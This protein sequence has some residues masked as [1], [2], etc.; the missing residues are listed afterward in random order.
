[1]SLSDLGDSLNRHLAKAGRILVVD[2]DD[3]TR[4]VIEGQL[5]DLGFVVCTVHNG[6]AALTELERFN[7]DLVLLDLRMPV[8]DGFRTLHLLRRS[9]KHADIPVVICSATEISASERALLS[10]SAQGRIDKSDL[11][12]KTLQRAMAKAWGTMPRAIRLSREES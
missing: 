1:M 6:L 9:A 8:M 2:D 5:S 4:V 3:D 11:S 10:Q 7:P 12:A